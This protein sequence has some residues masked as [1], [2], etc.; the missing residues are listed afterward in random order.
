MPTQIIDSAAAAAQD[1]IQDAI[2]NMNK[3]LISSQKKKQ[4]QQSGNGNTSS[5]PARHQVDYSSSLFRDEVVQQE[6]RY[7]DSVL[8]ADNNGV[9]G[10]GYNLP[11]YNPTLRFGDGQ[12]NVR[13]SSKNNSRETQKQS[14]SSPYRSTPS[15][16]PASNRQHRTP[17]RSRCHVRSRNTRRQTN[18]RLIQKAKLSSRRVMKKLSG[19]GKRVT[20]AIHNQ[21]LVAV[22]NM[23]SL[24]E[25]NNGSSSFGGDNAA[26]SNNNRRRR[27][28]ER[29]SLS[30]NYYID[31]IS[32]WIKNRTQN[33][34]SRAVVTARQTLRNRN[35]NVSFM[36]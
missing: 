22:A 11:P 23:T 5:S 16:V 21:I 24:L 32:L 8:R 18:R 31:N 14:A 19:I 4:Q 15:T 33:I 10:C 34:S 3:N 17:N 1:D 25:N 26:S 20:N 36:V 30:Q 35:N 29:A 7:F 9:G 12:S 13:V 28:P 6:M 2:S 27:V